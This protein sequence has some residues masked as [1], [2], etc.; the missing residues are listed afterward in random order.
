MSNWQR[1][2]RQ[3]KQKAKPLEFRKAAT[4]SIGP[5][6]IIYFNEPALVMVGAST[7]KCVELYFNK[8]RCMIGFCFSRTHTEDSRNLHSNKGLA[9]RRMSG[10]GFLKFFGASPPKETLRL[11]PKVENGM[12]VVHLPND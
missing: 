10:K 2:V 8:R 12:L 7:M 3:N 1:Y 6:G 4:V 9:T 5:D 11:T